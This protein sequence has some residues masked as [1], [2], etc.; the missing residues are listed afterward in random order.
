MI[1]P[2]LISSHR[3]APGIGTD[4]YVPIPTTYS[5]KIEQSAQGYVCSSRAHAN[6]PRDYIYGICKTC[7]A[8]MISRSV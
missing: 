3:R 5:N 2:V 4:L 7:I 6:A 8:Q 1:T